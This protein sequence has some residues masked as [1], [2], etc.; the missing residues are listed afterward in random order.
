MLLPPKE[1][2]SLRGVRAAQLSASTLAQLRASTCDFGWLRCG[3]HATLVQLQRGEDTLEAILLDDE[4]MKALH[5][6]AEGALVRVTVVPA[7]RVAAWS[8]LRLSPAAG[9]AASH[10]PSETEVQFALFYQH[11]R[12]SHP[13]RSDCRCRW[14][15]LPRVCHVQLRPPSQADAIECAAEGSRAPRAADGSLPSPRVCG[16]GSPS[17]PVCGE[18]TPSE[19]GPP[20]RAPQE[21]PSELELREWGMVSAAT[22]IEFGDLPP[23]GAAAPPL[24]E[25]REGEAAAV[26]LAVLRHARASAERGAAPPHAAGRSALLYGAAGVGKTALV[27]RLCARLALPLLRVTPSELARR[28]EEAGVGAWLQHARRCRPSAILIDPID[29]VAPHDAAA[30]GGGGE[31]RM[32]DAVLW[33]LQQARRT[34][35]ICVVAAADTP[36]AVHPEVRACFDV[37]VHVRPPSLTGR[38]E[39]LS[40]H[41]RL[42]GVAPPRADLALRLCRSMHGFVAADVAAVAEEAALLTRM[43][44]HA[45]EDAAGVSDALRHLSLHEEARDEEWEAAA[46]R[47]KPSGLLELLPPGGGGGGGAAAG[48]AAVGG[49][50]RVKARLAQLVLWP[51]RAPALCARLHLSGPRGV[52]LYG[53]PG[54]GKTLLVRALAA[55]AQLNL[56]AVP[57]PQL[58]KSEVGGS[59]RAL[60][61]LFERARAH[62]PCLL[63]IDELQALF[64]SRG[65]M[66]AV[67]RHMLSQLLLEIDLAHA[68]AREAFECTAADGALPTDRVLVI[69]GATNTPW[70]IDGALLRPGRLE[71]ALYIP[72]PAAEGRV[73]ILARR[74]AGMPLDQAVGPLSESLAQRTDGWTG[75]DLASLCQRA[76]M[77]ALGRSGAFEDASQ[78]GAPREMEAQPP[79]SFGEVV[80]LA[81]DFEAAL[82]SLRPS[83]TPEMVHALERWGRA[84]GSGGWAPGEPQ[85]EPVTNAPAGA[86]PVFAFSSANTDM[87]VF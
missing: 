82:S 66:G 81:T 6:G 22:A 20:E 76:A 2:S 42:A 1:A 59:E 73:E 24:A 78:D 7:S 60:A 83:V 4:S 17:P 9:C 28:A 19:D 79:Q 77:N 85:E 72:P 45:A 35:G 58:I 46:A 70:A 57:I 48:W 67:G 63:F 39:I 25:G 75:A 50:S 27:L 40:R 56:L 44:P 38:V 11:G 12:P 41:A 13:W 51:L 10:L 69:M 34:R 84:Q 52:L 36:A 61:A 26:L 74:L 33:L 49:V 47:V 64:G 18:P 37:I 32:L 87:P 8:T 71:H 15:L 80:V 68:E 65:D 62:S 54:T 55:E 43:R 16:D 23:D 86:A 53:P 3:P 14:A 31:W 30:S 29:A 21:E 5:C